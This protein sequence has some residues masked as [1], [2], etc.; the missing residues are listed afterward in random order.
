MNKFDIKD[1]IDAYIYKSYNVISDTKFLF[2][3]KA[4]QVLARN[5]RFIG[6]D[7]RKRCFIMGTGPSINNLS[8]ELIDKLANE[9]V[10]GVNFLYKSK[11]FKKVMPTHYVLM[12]GAFWG[13]YS[14][15]FRDVL[16]C[17]ENVDQPTFITDLR[18]KSFLE[19]EGINDAFYVYAKKYPVD[20]VFL[21]FSKNTSA[22]NN[23]VSYAISAAI[24]MG[25]EE[26][27]LLGCDYNAFCTSGVG[28]CYDDD[29]LK[30]SG[31][32]LS[33]FLKFYY[34]TTVFHYLL[35]K[36]S[37]DLGVKVINLTDGSL[38]DA[39]PRKSSDY[40]L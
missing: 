19:L 39:Y 10:F 13:E 3:I 11:V 7:E 2:N 14:N 20:D 33:Y 40:I 37:K 15:V 31:L 25:Y 36:K 12:D 26:I 28:H 16:S 22:L 1:K 17:Y 4:K 23:V 30:N 6:A 18:A 21:D 9:T 32:N 38:L 34:I 27:Y 29:E 8:E 5:K 24:Y 35:S